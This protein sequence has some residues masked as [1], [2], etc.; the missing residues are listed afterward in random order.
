MSL[1][2]KSDRK[3]MEEIVAEDFRNSGLMRRGS[4]LSYIMDMLTD[5]QH[6][7]DAVNVEKTKELDAAFARTLDSL[8]REGAHNL[9][10]V[11]YSTVYNVFSENQIEAIL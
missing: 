2:S 1:L 6:A 5:V 3:V 4:S 9:D 8:E 10:D 11:G 7:Y